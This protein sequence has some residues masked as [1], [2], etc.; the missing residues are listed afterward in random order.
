M[1]SGNTAA[2]D[3]QGLGHP[4]GSSGMKF[5]LYGQE[6]EDFLGTEGNILLAQLIIVSST[7]VA[8]RNGMSG[9]D[10]DSSS[11]NTT[12]VYTVTVTVKVTMK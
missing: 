6:A 3:E 8:T 1:A 12:L 5:F 2:A 11:P 9:N 10:H 7:M 4:H